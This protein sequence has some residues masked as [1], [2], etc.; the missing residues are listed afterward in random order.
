MDDHPSI[1]TK[2][3]TLAHKHYDWVKEKMDKL[4]E[5]GIIRRAIQAN[6]LPFCST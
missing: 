3:Y 2:P 4:L 1:A 5:A 6:Q